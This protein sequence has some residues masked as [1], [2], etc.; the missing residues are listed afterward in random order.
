VTVTKRTISKKRS[1]STLAKAL[2][3]LSASLLA[4]CGSDEDPIDTLSEGNVGEGT[5]PTDPL[6]V[7]ATSF[8]TGDDLET[9]LVTSD[10]FD[11]STV[12]NPTAG[13][14]L[15]GGIDLVV[16]GGAVF[17]PD[18]NGPV[19][20][21][22]QLDANNQ[23]VRGAEL[24]FAG[25]GMT[26]LSGGHVYV[27]DET[28]GYVFDPAGPRIIVWNPQTMLLTGEQI[29]LAAI[30]R[31]GWTPNINLGLV[32]LGAIRRGQELLIPLNW[33]DQDGNSRYASGLLAIDTTTDQV[34][35]VDEDERC[36]ETF[37]NLAAPNGDIY[38]FPPAWSSTQHYFID[39]HQP[40]CVLRVR[41][42]EAAF[43]RDYQL[44]LSSLGSG[45]AATGAIPD[46]DSG[47]Y[48]FT[49]DE[50]LWNARS[51]DLDSFWRISHYDFASQ[52][53]REISSLPIWKGHAHY[54]NMS[55]EIV[56]VFWEE[57]DTGNRTTF[58]RANGDGEPTR[59]FSYDA[60][61]YSFARIR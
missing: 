46:G 59:L 19:L 24:S 39:L 61:W 40:T 15:L 60:S 56:F 32:N 14:K 30:S 4:A 20:I 52:Q 26:S 25:V 8:I 47:F 44:D 53:A 10:T 36:G 38:F 21:R 23:L 31:P 43:D 58:Y 51:E 16:G 29:D 27:V 2:V 49:V 34:L 5:A 17:A 35:G 7:V 41:A 48:F 33:Q 57:T 28:K 54:V 11:E 18:S 9:Y 12:I 1:A 55:G 3:A 22:Y 6:Y 42:G 13:P 37:T 45:S 50:T